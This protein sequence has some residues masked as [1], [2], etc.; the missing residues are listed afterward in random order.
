MG[1]DA[2]GRNGLSAVT[3]DNATYEVE[4]AALSRLLSTLR[5]TGIILTLLTGLGWTAAVSA[6]LGALLVASL[7]WWGGD[8]LR[9]AGWLICLATAVCVFFLTTVVPYRKLKRPDAVAKRI[10]EVYPALASRVLSASQM[11][12]DPSS[13]AFSP[14]MVS[15]HLR[16]V[17]EAVAERVP[18]DRVFPKRRMAVPAFFLTA[19]ISGAAAAFA[20]APQIMEVGLGSLM[21]E[22]RPPSRRNRRISAK[23]PVVGDLAVLLKYPEYLGRPDRN[24]DSISGGFVAPLG[25]T[26]ILK[27]RALVPEAEKGE[28]HLPDGGRT[29][30][31]VGDKGMVR[32]SFVVASGGPFYLSLGTDNVMIEGPVRNIE[33]E[34]DASPAIRLLRPTGKV[35]LSADDELILELEAEDD[36]AISHIDVVLRFGE[37]T[38][39]RKTIVRFADTIK[40]IKTKYRW[41]P[42]S[43]RIGDE[44]ILK[45]ELEAFDNDTIMGP[46]PGR[47]E[48]LTI[49]FLTAHS[50]HIS[51]LEEQNS[52]LDG[53][54]DLLAYRLETP[55]P[56]SKQ[57]DEA[58]ARF[59]IIRGQT[60][61][62]LAK[63]AT[64]IGVLN[65][66][67]LTPK[68]VVD[69]FVQIRQD[70]SNQL[71]FEARLYEDDALG[72]FKDRLG[73]DR[74]TRRLLE[75][76]VVRVDDLIIDQQLSRVVHTGST[77][78]TE[79]TEL[80][81]LLARYME[82]R[83]ESVRRALLEAIGNMEKEVR[84]LEKHLEQVRGKVGDAYL[85]PSAM[86]QMDLLGSLS[87]LRD[88]LADDEVKDAVAL[89][90]RMET[91]LGRLLA[92]LEGGLLSFRTER[93]GEGE[94][95]LGE[96]LDR[97][98]GLESGQLQ[99]RRE[100]IALK[101]N[102]QER[103]NDVM[104]GKINPLVKKQLKRVDKMTQLIGRLKAPGNTP[105]EALLERLK[106]AVSELGLALNQ[107]DL[108]EARQVTEEVGEASDEWLL[109]I[110]KNPPA[111]LEILSKE[112]AGLIAEIN[113]AYPKPQELLGEKDTKTARVRAQDQRELLAKT[114]KLR[115]WIKRQSE[116]TRFLSHRAL[117][118]LTQVMR[119]MS[120]SAAGLESRQ[121]GE[122]LEEQSEALDELAR[123]REDLK[124]GDEAA[125]FESRPVVLGG[126]V[127]LPD[128]D[129]F[130]V[131]PEF[132][133]DILEAMRGDLPNQYEEAIKR[134]YER[135]VK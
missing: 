81:R 9:L 63:A 29:A 102:Y 32:G 122:A 20:A 119:R 19:A 45:L 38:A 55:V 46:K 40:R 57:S 88:L 22:R 11:A 126:R 31:S 75:R 37:E 66:D 12:S 79:R 129:E 69:T 68:R 10:G 59:G 1:V 18:E 93:F 121:I 35:E 133:D 24:L 107:G 117:E 125:P 47:T 16:T 48:P 13:R 96:L 5:R 74:V 100:T 94:R 56:S 36:H 15:A 90:H 83:S 73:V 53:L 64:L 135:L 115:T 104:R 124:R 97:V 127:T 120:R 39:L 91:D 99:L 30:L 8:A 110:R 60:E 82:T 84:K 123:L 25:T 109:G 89:V 42:E 130:E 95:F 33:T 21:A 128:P 3:N 118:S 112:A 50:R 49:Q 78:E 44:T 70:L 114:R 86:V 61:D 134:Y 92:G 76:A 132:R 65:R 41:S 80:S 14:F 58:T 72:E 34:V 111:A 51:A 105:E 54:I 87:T 2:F 103:L 27:G 26:V 17:R 67:T 71:M 7:G 108:D 116:E 52:A 113:D 43:I 4:A 77:L 23:A 85:N 6:V 62:L 28:I 106:K 101:R 131:P 98:M